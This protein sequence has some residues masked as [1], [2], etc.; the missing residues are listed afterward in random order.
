[1]SDTI[2]QENGFDQHIFVPQ[3]CFIRKC[4]KVTGIV[5]KIVA[6]VLFPGAS[7][8]M[9]SVKQNVESKY[10]LVVHGHGSFLCYGLQITQKDDFNISING[11]QKI[12]A[13]ETYSSL[14]TEERTLE[15]SE[16]SFNLA[17]PDL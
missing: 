13:L 3:I 6:V 7:D 9:L 15:T 8:A 5:V 16:M 11:D 2:F 17:L 4:G 1:M 12:S 14:E 10:N